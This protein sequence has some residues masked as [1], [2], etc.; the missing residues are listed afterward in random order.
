VIQR[1]LWFK[2]RQPQWQIDPAPLPP[3]PTHKFQENEESKV[4]PTFEAQPHQGDDA[5]LPTNV[6]A[7]S[8]IG[9]SSPSNYDNKQFFWI[10]C[11]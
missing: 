11:D 2:L 10:P 1:A 6:V 5:P 3:S 9:R 4:Q 8:S 7:S